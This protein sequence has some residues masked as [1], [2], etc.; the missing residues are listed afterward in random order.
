VDAVA[1]EAAVAED[2]PGLRAGE[3]VRDASADLFP[4]AAV[5]IALLERG[6][7]TRMK[8]GQAMTFWMPA[9]CLA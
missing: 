2:L 8:R 9:Q 3:G 6:P 4:S 7:V 5:A 1:L